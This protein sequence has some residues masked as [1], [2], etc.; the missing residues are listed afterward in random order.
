MVAATSGYKCE[1]GV[2]CPVKGFSYYL[3]GI[4]V[5][6]NCGIA[7]A[8]IVQPRFFGRKFNLCAKIRAKLFGAKTKRRKKKKGGLSDM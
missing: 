2:T 4:A 6:I 1:P 3:I 7:G 5:F 8:F